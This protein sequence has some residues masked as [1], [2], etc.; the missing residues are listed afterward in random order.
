MYKF[1]KNS[2]KRLKTCHKD[3]Q[4][5]FS[6]V[7]KYFD[8][9]IIYGYRSPE[10]QFE[11]YKKGRKLEN[12]IWIIDDQDKIVTYKDGYRKKSKHNTNPSDAIDVIPYPIEWK[13]TN[14]MRFFIGFVKGIAQMLKDTNQIDYEIVTG[15]DWDNDTI[16]K[17]QRFNDIP[18]FQIKK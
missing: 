18:H 10:E 2:K 6:Y 3:L 1:S 12:D 17:D 4:V 5:L 13:N 8:C 11:L 14:R 15:I 7:I 16:L 9:S